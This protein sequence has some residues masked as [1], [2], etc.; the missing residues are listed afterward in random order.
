MRRHGSL[1]SVCEKESVVSDRLVTL[2]AP[3]VMGGGHL[4]LALR[5]PEGEHAV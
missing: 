1:S 5:E 3:R 2:T 4:A